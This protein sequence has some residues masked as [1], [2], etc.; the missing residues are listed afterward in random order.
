MFQ[1]AAYRGGT[2]ECYLHLIN[3]NTF[4]DFVCCSAV[5]AKSD[6]GASKLTTRFVYI[7]L[8]VNRALM[9]TC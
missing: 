8:N 3:D 5:N 7:T 2:N 6:K 1:T 4:I 9:I